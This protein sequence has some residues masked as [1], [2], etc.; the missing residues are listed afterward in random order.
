MF[1]KFIRLF[2]VKEDTTLDYMDPDKLLKPNKKVLRDPLNQ[3]DED[4]FFR[5]LDA[6]RDALESF[7]AQDKIPLFNEEE[8]PFRESVL[9][10]MRQCMQEKDWNPKHHPKL[11]LSIA[12]I[13]SATALTIFILH[14]TPNPLLGK[15]KPLGKNI[16]LPTGDI[17]FSKDKV[18]AMGNSTPVKYDIEEHSIEVIDLTTKMRLTFFIKDEK[19]IELTILGVKTSYKKADK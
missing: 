6:E 5:E 12:F 13:L 15:W 1:A 3:E 11:L 16:F 10:K 18:Q 14:E 7:E 4:A 2:K 17:E 19:N 8:A 9:K